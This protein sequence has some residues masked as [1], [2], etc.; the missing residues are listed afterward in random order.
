MCGVPGV[1]V[2]VWSTHCCGIL[3]V[4]ATLF[5]HIEVCCVMLRIHQ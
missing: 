1:S 3:D 5:K 4:F 2:S